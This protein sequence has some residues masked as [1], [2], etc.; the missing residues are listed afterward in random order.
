MGQSLQVANVPNAPA[1][2]ARKTSAQSFTQNA[3]TK[4]IFNTEEFD[5]NSNYDTTNGRFTPTVAGY[6]QINAGV[7]LQTLIRG[8]SLV[9]IFKNGSEYKRGQHINTDLA[10]STDGITA[11]TT[12]GLVYCNGTTDYIEIHGYFSSS[13]VQADVVTPICFFDGCLVRP[14]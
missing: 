10:T 7:V 9:S 13:G 6:Y 8:T 2:S 4:V 11:L 3:F 12:H 1:F 5:T 14:A